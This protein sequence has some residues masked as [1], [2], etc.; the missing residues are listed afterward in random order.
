MASL[1]LLGGSICLDVSAAEEHSIETW[2]TE[3]V[4]KHNFTNCYLQAYNK[5]DKELNRVY[6]TLMSK[7]K[8]NHKVKNDLQKA[9]IAWLK[10]KK[11]EEKATASIYRLIEGT[12]RSELEVYTDVD[13]VKQR[14]FMLADYLTELEYK[15]Q[16][17]QE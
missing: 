8:N 4:E 1:L 10:Y 6:K 14:S 17:S 16:D 7:L 9:Q 12:T 5:W 15:E 3:C 2:T 13:V 11:A